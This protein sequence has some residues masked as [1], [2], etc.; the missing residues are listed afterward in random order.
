MDWL[1]SDPPNCGEIHHESFSLNARETEIEEN[2]TM[3]AHE[4]S[5]PLAS[6]KIFATELNKKYS[7]DPYI[8]NN[9]S[10]IKNYSLTGLI[11]C[12]Q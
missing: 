10:K 8:S 12:R 2:M 11:M 7:E 3:I 1:L 4:L 9:S 5:G 6:I